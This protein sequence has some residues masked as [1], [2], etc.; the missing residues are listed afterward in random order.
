M[1][2]PLLPVKSIR[3]SPHAGSPAWM[4]SQPHSLGM[5]AQVLRMCTLPEISA[6]G[7]QG[8]T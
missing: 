6:A 3:L 4:A 5:R 7:E 2:Q 8:V 1:T